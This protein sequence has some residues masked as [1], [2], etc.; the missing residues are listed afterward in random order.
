MVRQN[1]HFYYTSININHNISSIALVG[2]LA[3]Y[4]NE[5]IFGVMLIFTSICSATYH[6]H[7]EG[8]YFNAD[9]IL[10]TAVGIIYLYTL[11]ISFMHYDENEILCISGTLGLFLAAFLLVYC[12]MPAIIHMQNGCCIRNPNPMYALIHTMW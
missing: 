2:I 8:M 11:F 7:N 5:S 6:Y 3:I 4:Y 1:I 9:N 12:G 10:A